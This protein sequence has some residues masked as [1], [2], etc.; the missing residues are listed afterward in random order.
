MCGGKAVFSFWP[1]Y[2]FKLLI[3]IFRPGQFF[4]L[5]FKPIGGSKYIFTTLRRQ[6]FLDDVVNLVVYTLPSDT[7]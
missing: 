1:K 6:L 2:D 5:F 4:I 3:I 7:V